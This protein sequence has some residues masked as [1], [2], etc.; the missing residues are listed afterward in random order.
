[1]ET[2]LPKVLPLNLCSVDGATVTNIRN[3]QFGCPNV[4]HAILGMRQALGPQYNT[5]VKLM[6]PHTVLLQGQERS[7]P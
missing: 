1:M 5:R 4:D 7:I 3:T 6:Y 2:K